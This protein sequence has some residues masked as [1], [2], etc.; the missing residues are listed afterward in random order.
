M[1]LDNNDINLLVKEK[2]IKA[3]YSRRK[4]LLLIHLKFA[5]G[6]A[7][8]KKI[9]IKMRHLLAALKLKPSFKYLIMILLAFILPCNWTRKFKEYPLIYNLVKANK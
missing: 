9:K 8:R 6:Y 4:L 2:A 7:R 1:P 3:D 5:D